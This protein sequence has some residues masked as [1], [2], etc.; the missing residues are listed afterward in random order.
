M[1]NQNLLLQTDYL[2]VLTFMSKT[3]QREYRTQR[4]GKP[5]P[6]ELQ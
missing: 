4:V 6:Y 5:N 1:R 2:G 3:C